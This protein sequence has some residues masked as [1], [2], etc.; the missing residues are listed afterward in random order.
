MLNP[1]FLN[2]YISIHN[3]ILILFAG[4]VNISCKK[5]VIKM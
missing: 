1:N 3:S 5:I 2:I 4:G